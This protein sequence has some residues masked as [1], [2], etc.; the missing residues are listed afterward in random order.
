ML[1]T[2]AYVCARRT[3][4]IYIHFNLQVTASCSVHINFY[5]EVSPEGFT[6]SSKS[7]QVSSFKIQYLACRLAGWENYHNIPVYSASRPLCQGINRV[8]IQRTNIAVSIYPRFNVAG[9]GAGCGTGYR[10]LLQP[11]FRAGRRNGGYSYN[12]AM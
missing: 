11:I 8:P 7:S 4:L 12:P 1:R 6:E 5:P 9:G 3:W 10:Q 2:W